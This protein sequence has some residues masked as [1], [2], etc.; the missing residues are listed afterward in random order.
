MTKTKIRDDDDDVFDKNGLLKD[1]KHAT[2]PMFMRDGKPNP[3]L[4]PSQR[5]AA[6]VAATKDAM[7]SFDSSM[8][9]IHRPGFRYSADTAAGTVDSAAAD[10][11][12]TARDAAYSDYQRRQSD[13]WKTGRTRDAEVPPDGSYPASDYDEGDSC[14]VGGQAGTL[15]L[16]DG[17][18]DYL[19]CVANDSG[20][21]G[22]GDS[23]TT[24]DTRTPQQIRD[25]AYQE[26]DSDITNS[27]RNK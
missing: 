1:G 18:E 20:D 9:R 24:H 13:A 12:I 15:Q 21:D 2:V 25:A 17:Y 7:R 10:A 19:E 8:H 6:A 23:R 3:D 14:T 27:W 16:I 5:V 11:A 22:T 4:T 26:Y